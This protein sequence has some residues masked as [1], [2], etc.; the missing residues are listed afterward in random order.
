MQPFFTLRRLGLLLLFWLFPQ[1]TFAGMIR[2]TELE[3]GLESLA[4]PLVRA[5]GFGADK[6]NI[7]IIID[8]N[9]NAFVAGELTIYVNSGLLLDAQSIE[10]ILGVL[11]HEL[12]HLKAGHVPRRDDNI[13][14]ATAANALAA[15]AALALAAGGAPSDATMGVIIGG[16][17]LAKRKIL[18]GYRRDESVA[19]E[20]GLRFLDASGVSSRGLAE[21]MRRMA[22][23]SALPESH[24]HTYYQTHPGASE[25]LAVYQDHLARSDHAD[26]HVA[27]DVQRIATRLIDKLRAY[28]DP[29]QSILRDASRL[30]PENRIYSQAIAHYR[31]GDLA[32]ALALINQN[33]KS[34]VDDPFYHEL[35]GDIL[36]SMA[37]PA[38]AANSYETSVSLRPNS[39]QILLNLGRAILATNDKT[40]LGRAIQAIQDAVT[41]EPKWAF[42]HRQLAIAYGRAGKIANADL[43]LAE[44]AIL[45][46][47][48]QQAR[49]MAK[50]ALNHTDSDIDLKN[51]ANDILFSV[52]NDN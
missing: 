26:S 39:P 13:R 45:L 20:L 29:P 50:R 30:A 49:N 25:R 9:Y 7:R 38:T 14:E 18:H 46:N 23:Q 28:T 42:A 41:G 22:A 52:G 44:E 24:Q 31:R 47:D 48:R 40:H 35:R 2:D 4:A 17:D 8:Q 1:I 15:I 32:T 10:E 43:A 51:R 19:D 5:A 11:A 16:T 21:M 37:K 27:D 36:M 33:I 12:G 34:D 6:V 3:A